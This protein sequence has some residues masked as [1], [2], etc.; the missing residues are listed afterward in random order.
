MVGSDLRDGNDEAITSSGDDNTG[1]N[2]WSTRC[3]I[4]S[5]ISGCNEKC[6]LKGS[7]VAD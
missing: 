1:H 5:A 4:T 3:S 6:G 2:R 7:S